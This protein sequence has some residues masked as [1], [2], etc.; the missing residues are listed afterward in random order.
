[1]CNMHVGWVRRVRPCTARHTIRSGGRIL[2]AAMTNESLL[3]EN[4]LAAVAF[5]LL[6][7]SSIER[8][9]HVARDAAARL[10]KQLQHVPTQWMRVVE[11]AEH[12]W[13]EAVQGTHREP[14]EVELAVLLSALARTATPGVDDLLAI[15]SLIDQPPVAW[16]SALARNLRM[17]R[18]AT[19]TLGRPA[20]LIGNVNN[21]AAVGP[22]PN[23]PRRKNEIV[24]MR[25]SA[26]A[27]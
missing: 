6:T 7:S 27:A 24:V 13:R 14:A 18:S 2:G 22:P 26:T 23:H 16:L 17:H 19:L 25:S 12:L 1:M 5:G 20:T 11:R 10:T 4:E 3:P 15:I 8:Y 9:V 21:S